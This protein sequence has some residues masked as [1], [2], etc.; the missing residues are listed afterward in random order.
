MNEVDPSSMADENVSS[1]I[2]LSTDCATSISFTETVPCYS[3]LAGA[4]RA[5]FCMVHENWDGSAP[6]HKKMFCLHYM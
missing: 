1:G 6:F 2:A 5:F 3:R 4:F